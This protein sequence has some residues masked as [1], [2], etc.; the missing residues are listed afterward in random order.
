M[1]DKTP[2]RTVFNS[3][4]VATGL[5]EFQSGETVGGTHGGIGTSLS[6]GSA[7]QVLKVNSGAS[8]LEFGFVEAIVNIDNATNLTSATLATSDQILIS[9]GGTEGRATLAQLDT[10]FS[11]TSKT[12]TN[13]TLTSPQINTNIDMLA[14]AELRFQDASGGQYVAL[15][16]PATVSSNITFVLPSADGSASQAIVTDGSGNLS[17]GDVSVL[18]E[19]NFASN[20]ATRAPSQQSTKAFVEASVFG[21]FNNSIFTVAPASEGN[22]DLAKQQDQTGSVETPFVAGGTDAFGVS[23][24]EVYDPMEPIGSLVTVDLG[25]VA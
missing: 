3:D 10:L 11:G 21:G 13:K 18:D 14:R 9:D 15:E 12:L 1:A 4:N 7:G 23:L 16:A 24:G 22:F 19:D 5:A 25:S 6:I 8:A 20:S 2:I 17:F